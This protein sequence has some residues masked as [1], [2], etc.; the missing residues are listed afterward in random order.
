MAV[1]TPQS[2][3]ARAPQPAAPAAD[4]PAPP[5]QA[6]PVPAAPAEPAMG[7]LLE[8]QPDRKP[9]KAAPEPTPVQRMAGIVAVLVM[10]LVVIAGAAWQARRPF[11]R[12]G[13]PG[14]ARS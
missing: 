3:A 1:A 8:R 4:L 11:A 6:K 14:L 12:Y 2:P 7:V 10:A 5:P 13:R 9:P